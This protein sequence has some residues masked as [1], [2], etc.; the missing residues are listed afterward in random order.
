LTWQN[1]AWV[2]TNQIR[3][4]YDGP[5]VIQERDTNNNP[6]VTYTRGLDLS[7]SLRGACW[8]E[9]TATAQRVITA[10]ATATSPP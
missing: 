1:S 3:Y 2:Q 10:T 7:L 8:R 9:P 6:Q 4:V 5:L